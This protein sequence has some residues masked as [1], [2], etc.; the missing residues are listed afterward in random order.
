M[1]VKCRVSKKV[2]FTILSICRLDFPPTMGSMSLKTVFGHFLQRLS[3]IKSSQVY[4]LENLAPQNPTL[5][6]IF[7]LKMVSREALTW[8]PK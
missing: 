6:M 7:G 1:V 3:R 2:S 4:V 5:V 8:A